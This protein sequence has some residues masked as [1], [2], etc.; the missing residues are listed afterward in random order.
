MCS[1]VPF[2]S[3][4]DWPC[5]LE[6]FFSDLAVDVQFASDRSASRPSSMKLG[7]SGVRLAQLVHVVRWMHFFQ[8]F[9][10]C[11]SLSHSIKNRFVFMQFQC[12]SPGNDNFP[13][14]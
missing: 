6:S 14:W 7:C 12:L 9:F 3:L 11:C 1:P 8:V 13:L 2:Q 10:V 4:V 5:S